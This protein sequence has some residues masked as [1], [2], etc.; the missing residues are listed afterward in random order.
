MS[1]YAQYMMPTAFFVLALTLILT[2]LISI[3]MSTIPQMILDR[4]EMPHDVRQKQDTKRIT[5]LVV[6]LSTL[7]VLPLH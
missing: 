2:A 5:A 7:W 1:T 4:A 6:L 3:A